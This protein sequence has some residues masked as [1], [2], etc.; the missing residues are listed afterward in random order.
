MKI[1][2]TAPLE[3]MHGIVQPLGA[4]IQVSDEDGAA[5]IALGHIQ[6]DEN[7]PAKINPEAYDLGCIPLPPPAPAPP[8]ETEQPATAF[9][10][11]RK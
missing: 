1:R 6:V 2:L 4:V 8:T 11:F 7:T 9:R 10:F 3:I 5:L